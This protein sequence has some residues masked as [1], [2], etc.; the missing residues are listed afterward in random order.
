VAIIALAG[1]GAKVFSGRGRV[2]RRLWPRSSVCPIG[3]A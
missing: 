3:R 2:S 1:P